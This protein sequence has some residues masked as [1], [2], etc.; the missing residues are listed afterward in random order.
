MQLDQVT[1]KNMEAGLRVV[2]VGTSIEVLA[3][4]AKR[5]DVFICSEVIE[6][7]ECS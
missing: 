1:E 2:A 5:Y 7:V 3:A 6:L 4:S